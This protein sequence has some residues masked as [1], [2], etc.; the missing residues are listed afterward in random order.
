[1]TEIFNGIGKA[2]ESIFPILPPIG[3]ILNWM[4]GITIAVGTA[5]WLW[6]DS[7]VRRGGN[8]YMAKK[9]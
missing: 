1:M 7:K 9:G 4:F 5:Y 8:N 3:F 2:A 6:Y